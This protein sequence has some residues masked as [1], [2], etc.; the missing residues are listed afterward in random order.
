MKLDKTPNLRATISNALL[1]CKTDCFFVALEFSIFACFRDSLEE[2]ENLI[3][4]AKYSFA[5]YIRW[6]QEDL[7]KEL[8]R[9]KNLSKAEFE[10]LDVVLIIVYLI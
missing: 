8:E 1:L 2:S 3:E 4:N 6:Y 9:C 7:S 5:P 10:K